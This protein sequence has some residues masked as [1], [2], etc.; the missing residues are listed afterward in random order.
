M[1]VNQSEESEWVPASSPPRAQR[2]RN[3]TAGRHVRLA[4]MTAPQLVKCGVVRVR[5]DRSSH[6]REDEWILELFIKPPDFGTMM[7]ASSVSE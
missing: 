6:W 2:K 7:L 3:I 5:E 4:K 1:P